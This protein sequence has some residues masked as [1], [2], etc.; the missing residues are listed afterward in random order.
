[1]KNPPDNA[2]QAILAQWQEQEAAVRGRVSGRGVIP[3]GTAFHAR[4]LFDL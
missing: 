3:T 2:H 1:M 4:P